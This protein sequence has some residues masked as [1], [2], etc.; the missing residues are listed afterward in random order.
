MQ[1]VFGIIGAIAMIVIIV[2]AL[3]MTMA[4]GDSQK[5]ARARGTV[6]FALVGLAICVSAEAIIAFVIKNV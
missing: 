2:G 6:V 4:E 1:L 5:I 3:S